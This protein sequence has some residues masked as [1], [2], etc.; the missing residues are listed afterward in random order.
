LEQVQILVQLRILQ[1][2]FFLHFQKLVRDR[3]KCQRTTSQ[4]A[5][6]FFRSRKKCQGTTSVVPKMHQNSL[7]L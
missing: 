3:H 1:A 2:S 4:A 7:G 5:K 6:K